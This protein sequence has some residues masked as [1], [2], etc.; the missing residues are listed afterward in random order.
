MLSAF[1]EAAARS[2]RHVHAKQ[3]HALAAT[4]HV[5]LIARDTAMR[6]QNRANSLR[7][8]AEHRHQATFCEPAKR[9]LLQVST[10]T[11][12]AQTTRDEY[13]QTRTPSISALDNCKE[14]SKS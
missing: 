4:T 3:H 8:L 2:A 13:E 12:Q 14:R 7:S 6:W 5:E 10:L 9:L 11:V 1:Q